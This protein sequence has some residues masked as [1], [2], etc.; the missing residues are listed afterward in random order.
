MYFRNDLYY[1]IQAVILMQAKQ[2]NNSASSHEVENR[3]SYLLPIIGALIIPFFLGIF[4]PKYLIGIYNY[5]IFVTPIIIV[6][7]I[8][9]E[10]LYNGKSLTRGFFKYIKPMPSGVIY[11]SDIEEKGFPY[12]T[13]ILI[14]INTTLFFIL[15]DKVVDQ[16][17]FF[18]HGEPNIAQII[19]SIFSSAFLHGDAEHIA[20]N[21]LFLLV[22][23]ST[24]EPRI[25]MIRFLKSYIICII[26]S[27]LFLVIMLFYRNANYNKALAITDYHS[28]GASGAIAGLM[29][30]FAVR[31]YFGKM[32]FSLPV[33]FMP[34]LSIPFKVNALFI[35]CVFFAL[36]LKG[37][38]KQLNQNIGVNYWAHVGGY[39]SGF[40][41]AYCMNLHK[42]A[43]EESVPV[44]AKQASQHYY[45]KGEAVH[46]YKEILQNDPDNEEALD[47]LMRNYILTVQEKAKSYYLRLMNI[48]LKNKLSK[49]FELFNEYFPLYIRCIPCDA[50][51]RF[52]SNYYNQYDYKKA[53]H[54]FEIASENNS[55]WQAKA[56]L[57]YAE[58]LE[59]IGNI[60]GAQNELL[61][62]IELFP[63]SIFEKAAKD[64]LNYLSQNA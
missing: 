55:P 34:L 37:S 50:L 12:V 39:L 42:D 54:C 56:L 7:L 47:F 9:Y 45:K 35:I 32:K 29:G 17:V 11:G 33:F 38:V 25:G 49:A 8:Y 52:G 36:D 2:P 14:I 63:D 13:L 15:P 5:I 6:Y 59:A 4:N 40:V 16:F 62:L 1:A 57:S 21:M 64:K 30:M 19:L 23:G 26:F 53:K 31:C 46:L 10:W 24:I 48:L 20:Y 22:L 28:L 58:T 18:P 51:V 61:K 44:K 27:Q 41:M 60:E 43:A 3:L